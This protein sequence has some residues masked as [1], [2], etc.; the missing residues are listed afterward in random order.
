MDSR[1]N[2]KLRRNMMAKPCENDDRKGLTES[3]C[4]DASRCTDGTVLAMLDA[5]DR[6][7][8]RAFEVYGSCR[9]WEWRKRIETRTWAVALV[10]ARSIAF[11]AAKTKAATQEAGC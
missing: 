10:Y 1:F 9:W 8:M 4:D 7:G 11:N 3:P 6:E 2:I 5:M